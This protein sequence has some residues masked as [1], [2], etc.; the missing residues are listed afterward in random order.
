MSAVGGKAAIGRARFNV[1]YQSGH[2]PG[3]SQP[4]TFRH[5]AISGHAMKRL[6]VRT[7]RRVSLR[8]GQFLL[9]F[10]RADLLP[11]TRPTALKE[12]CVSKLADDH[13]I[14]AGVA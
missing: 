8:E 10:A 12:L 9:Q 2:R 6:A 3:L 4:S 11:V 1:R 7:R 5:K 14:E 13:R